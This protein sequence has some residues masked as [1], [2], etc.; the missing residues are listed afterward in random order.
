MTVPGDPA[1]RAARR[2]AVAG[3]GLLFSGCAGR[4]SALDPAGP[5][6]GRIYRLWWLYCGVSV[7]VYL[8]VMGLVIG[9][10]VRRGRRQKTAVIA[11]PS[12]KQER[13][14]TQAVGGGVALTTATLFLLLI[15][16]FTTGRAIHSLA[17]PDAL[18]IRVTGHQ[19]WWEVQYQD[20]T[21]SNIVTT[22][23]EIHIPVGRTVR[24]ELQSSDVIH[25]F[26]VPN[27]H[28]K[29]DMIPG[30][31]TR[32]YMRADRAGT[33][34]GQCAEFCGY[35]HSFMRFVVVAEAE[36]EFR[37][38]IE[39]Q[40]KPAPE[41]ATA[42]QRRGREVFLGGTCVMCHTIQGTPARSRV[43]PDLTHVGSRPLIG[44]ILPNARG[45]LAGWIVDPQ[46]I[47]P[48]VRMPLNVVK[49]TDLDA[50]VDYLTSLK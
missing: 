31:P 48:G 38:W 15:G 35:Q 20:P 32:A 10:L 50:L 34:R 16:D 33:Y 24:F 13:R 3:A 25:S 39:A 26:W 19:W 8:A 12:A 43:G 17:D 1:W 44:G 9:A 11:S 7:L 14:L 41:P 23:N 30:H 42:S 47:K 36:E 2:A 18:T 37:R 28:G 29:R 22:A 4:Q 27:L 5:Q 45:H 46:R 49:P 6:S 40:R 21:P